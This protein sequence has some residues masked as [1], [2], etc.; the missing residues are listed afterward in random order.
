MAR[1]T[2]RS[3]A[4]SGN[5]RPIWPR[6]RECWP[7]WTSTPRGSSRCSAGGRR[8]PS[9]STAPGSSGSRGTRS[10]PTPSA[11]SW[12]CSSSWPSTCR[13]PYRDRRTGARGG[14]ARSSPT[15]ASPVEACAG[16]T[17]RPRWPGC[18][19]RCSPSS[20]GSRSTRP[21]SCSRPGTPTTRG[22]GATRSSGP[23]WPRRS[24]PSSTVSWLTRSVAAATASWPRRSTSRPAWSTTTSDLNTSSS[25][26]S[27]GGSRAASSLRGQLDR[28][29]VVDVVPIAAVLGAGASGALLAGRDVGDRVGDRMW[30]Y[31]WMGSIHA[32]RYGVDEDRP[33]VR[34][35]GV[36]ELR[37]RIA[38]R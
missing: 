34:R 12:R 6:S 36:H 18:W 28:R 35:A 11:G 21:R 13:S 22:A 26:V 14:A 7:A 24:C 31:R 4:A 33:D 8:G 5:G 29:P 10:P 1:T 3:V 16:P 19:Q 30:F 23:R 27:T 38:A 17:P 32:V 37:R 20:T 25:M 2:P 15:G 9:T